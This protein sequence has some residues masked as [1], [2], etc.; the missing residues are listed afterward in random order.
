MITNILPRVAGLAVCVA[1]MSATS[2]TAVAQPVRDWNECTAN[3]DSVAAADLSIA[4]CTRAIQ[5]RRYKTSDLAVLFANRGLQRSYREDLAGGIED[6]TKA[7]ELDP[8]DATYLD[9]RGRLYRRLPQLGHVRAIS[10]FTQAIALNPQEAR[11]YYHRADSYTSEP[12]SDFVK[13]IADYTQAI[14]LDPNFAAAFRQRGSVYMLSTPRDFA[15]AM[16]DLNRAIELDPQ[17]AQNFVMRA[18]W[19]LILIARSRTSR[20]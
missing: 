10:D 5:S 2:I 6:L 12:V 16:S 9:N 15:R 14:T 8:L 7:I 4:A 17:D 3:S 1:A 13:A 19:R 11:Y 20:R 18:G